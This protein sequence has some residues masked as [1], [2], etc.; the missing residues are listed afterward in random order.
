MYI[1]LSLS[2]ASATCMQKNVGCLSHN[3]QGGSE[4]EKVSKHEMTEIG[5]RINK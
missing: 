5:S 2:E 3:T 4:T 1:W